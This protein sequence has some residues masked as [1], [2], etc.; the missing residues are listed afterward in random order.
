MAEGF[1]IVVRLAGEPE[2]KGRPRFAR[3][4]GRA[5]TPA[6][7]R[8]YEAALR[9]AA[10]EAMGERAPLE[11][12][13]FVT[14]TARLPVPASWSGK[15]QRAALAGDIWP[16]AGRDV[17]NYGKAAADALNTVVYRDDKQIVA[18]T[19]V[20][21]YGEKPEMRIVV[22]PAEQVAA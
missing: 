18:L 22:R 1:P 5:Y 11:G 2:G 15:K 13:L 8:K 10:Q 3:A 21:V 14:V 4:T 19:V 16:L 17:D 20:K 7:T 6:N 12:A 9:F